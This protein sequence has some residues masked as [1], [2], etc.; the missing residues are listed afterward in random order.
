MPSNVFATTGT[1]VSVVFFDKSGINDEVVL[2]D[3]SKMGEEY[4]ESNLL[5]RRLRVEEITQ[6]VE[7]FRDRN[8]IDDFSVS[9]S[10]EDIKEKNYSLAAAQYFDVKIEYITLTPE[11]FQTKFAEHHRSLADQFTQSQELQ[12]QILGGLGEIE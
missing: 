2:I 6:I 1:N 4:K 12:R 7:A 8:T 10:Y 11:Q 3:A 5:K 9:V